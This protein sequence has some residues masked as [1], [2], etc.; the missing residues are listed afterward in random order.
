MVQFAPI[1]SIG[2]GVPAT[3]G[4]GTCNAE[5]HTHR[6]LLI[7]LALLAVLWL[8]LGL[9]VVGVCVSAARGDRVLS[10]A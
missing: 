2:R 3:T 4:T 5:P 9:V 7:G 1:R 10:L 6:M 8:A